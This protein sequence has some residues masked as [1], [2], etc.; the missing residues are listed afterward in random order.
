MYLSAVRIIM[1]VG[2]LLLLLAFMAPLVF[3]QSIGKFVTCSDKFGKCEIDCISSIHAKKIA[4]DEL[5]L[6]TASCK[7][8]YKAC[9]VSTLRVYLS[10][11]VDRLINLFGVSLKADIAIHTLCMYV[12][13]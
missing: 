13:T 8:I 6:C 5:N 9:E 4:D 12:S 11:N 3:P 2:W 1:I 10:F 7:D